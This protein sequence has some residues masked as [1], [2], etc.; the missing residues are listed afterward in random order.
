MSNNTD[1]AALMQ[2]ITNASASQLLDSPLVADRFK[3]LYQKIHGIRDT[4]VA[5]AFYTAEKF[6]FLKIVN[7]S[8]NIAACTK[9]SLY[10]IFM[11]V[12]VSGLSFDP[13]MK[14]LY[15]VPYNTNVG[16][17]DAPRWEK[18]AALQIS[19]YG[20]LL[21]RQIQGQVKYADNPVIVYDCDEF[22][23][24]S[25]N[26]STILDHVALIPRKEDAKIVACYIKI[27]RHDNSIDYK[28]MTMEDLLALKK[29]S[30]DPN[31]LAWTSG[32]AGMMHSKTIKHAFKNYPK[33][34]V[35]EFSQLQSEVIDTETG[36]VT[37]SIIDYGFAEST[38]IAI[39]SAPVGGQIPQVQEIPEPLPVMQEHNQAQAA[40]Q[41]DLAF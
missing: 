31:S 2:L 20:E 11:D 30:K 3:E 39:E 22:K 32:L 27:T 34:R 40:P 13:S 6:H 24:G 41:I 29:F 19:G 21:L 23:F 7:D 8:T 18:R 28:V 25:R 16:T 38:P 26:G 1:K 4:T 9:L 12:A 36:E 15:I 10:G 37:S 14:H 33:L 35:G 17:K 5:D